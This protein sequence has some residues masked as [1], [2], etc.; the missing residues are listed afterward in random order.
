MYKLIKQS[1]FIIIR[2]KSNSLSLFYKK[3]FINIS[4]LFILKKLI[5]Y[6][7]LHNL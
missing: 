5:K 7:M 1:E 2:C 3:I 6:K 4:L